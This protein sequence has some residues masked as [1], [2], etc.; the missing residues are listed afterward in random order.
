MN[1]FVERPRFS[2]TLGGALTTVTAI[3]GAVP[4]VHASAGCGGNLFTAQQAGSG[5]FGSGYCGG[6]SVPGSNVAEH[7]IV[8]GGIERLSEQIDATLQLVEGDCYVVLTGC[9]TDI[10]GDDISTPVQEQ[11]AKGITIAGVETG[12]FKGTSYKGYDL[13]LGAL[14]SQ[15]VAEAA[16][17][18]S[19]LINLWGLVPG[20][21]PF[22]RGDLVELKRLLS[23]IGLRVNTFFAPGEGAADL[24]DAGCAVANIVVSQHYGIEAAKAFQARFG[25]PF[26]ALDL[27]IGPG[28][29]A[30]FLRQVG[31]FLR[32]DAAQIEEVIAQEE[33]EY[34][35]FIERVAD[36]YT[37]TDL[38][39]YAV[40]VGNATSAVPLTRFLAD[41]LGWHPSLVVVADHLA[42]GEQERLARGLD[43]LSFAARP[44]LVFETDASRIAVHLAKV[45][46]S[47]AGEKYPHRFAPAYI[48]GSTLEKE[49]ATA[50]GAKHLSVS[51]PVSNRVIINRGYAGYRGGLQLTE[52][53]L[54]ATFGA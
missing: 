29:S 15:I 9:M 36:F 7:E 8:F 27:P 1:D 33:R 22:F 46:P 49:L 41:E 23:L 51:F 26:L 47:H 40:V 11:R 30:S 2:C 10:I 6:L 4:I 54:T 31:A 52:D 19:D 39:H 5:Y 44:E 50:V 13:A 20:L 43:N 17:R 28:A 24:I 12:G 45:W 3:A 21:D 37:D 16:E 34:Y 53:L 48:V 32:R 42:E 25:T 14:F 38:Q 18:D 35:Q